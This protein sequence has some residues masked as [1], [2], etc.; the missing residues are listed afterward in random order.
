MYIV[1]YEG[2]DKRFDILILGGCK[3]ELGAWTK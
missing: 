2:K 3:L 1:Q